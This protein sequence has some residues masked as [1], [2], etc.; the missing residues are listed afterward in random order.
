[1][2]EGFNILEAELQK[3]QE[4]LAIA[5]TANR[6]DHRGCDA[7][8]SQLTDELAVCKDE[9]RQSNMVC[10]PG[11]SDAQLERFIEEHNAFG[12]DFGIRYMPDVP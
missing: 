2:V 10:D 4:K 12:I 7:R 3:T 5:E 8:I 6:P 9:L 11:F 1:M